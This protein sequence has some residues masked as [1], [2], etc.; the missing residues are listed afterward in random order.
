[1]TAPSLNAAKNETIETLAFL[2]LFKGAPG[3]FAKSNGL[4]FLEIGSGCAIS[5]PSAPTIVLNR[6]QGVEEELKESYNWLSR[7]GC[8]LSA[9]QHPDCFRRS[10]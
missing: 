8:A 5:L 9:N 10:A 2:K 6:I 3:G 1:M 7:R 4:S